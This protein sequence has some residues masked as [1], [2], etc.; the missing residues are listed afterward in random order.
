VFSTL[1]AAQRERLDRIVA[2]SDSIL[3]PDLT[4]GGADAANEPDGRSL[5]VGEIIRRIVHA[6]AGSRGG[7][8]VDASAGRHAGFTLIELMIVVAIIGLLASV[9]I[10]SFQRYQLRSKSSEVKS[11]LSAIRVVQEARYADL[12]RY[13]PALAEPPLIPG[14]VPAAFEISGTG[15]AE[16]GWSPDGR[17]YFSY[18]VATSADQTGYT[19]DAAADIDGNGILQIWGYVKP[20]PVGGTIVGQLGCD[21]ALLAPEHIGTCTGGS[22]AF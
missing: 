19:A 16:L 15:F 4:F 10:P 18:A 7:T 9:A 12:G 2:A 8:G 11:N 22:P 17:V 3:D 14:V 1:S 13:L 21:P 20:D 5:V 6:G